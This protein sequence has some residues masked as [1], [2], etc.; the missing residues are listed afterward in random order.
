MPAK[1]L[2]K[3]GDYI[4]L[5]RKLNWN[6]CCKFYIA[7]DGGR[8]ELRFSVL[9]DSNFVGQSVVSKELSKTGLWIKLWNHWFSTYAKC[10]DMYF[11]RIIL[12]VMENVA[13]PVAEY[14]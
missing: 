12:S 9:I 4:S 11:F 14:S 13:A 8:K 7:Y 5:Q 3:I 2:K 10:T 1:I 6:V